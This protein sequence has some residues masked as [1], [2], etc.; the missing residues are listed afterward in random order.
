M[1]FRYHF[2]KFRREWHPQESP[3]TVP[4]RGASKHRT[5]PDTEFRSKT[6]SGAVW[7]LFC[8]VLLHIFVDVGRLEAPYWL[9]FLVYV[10]CVVVVFG[11][12]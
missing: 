3:K 4:G 9:Q 12:A 6:V 2:P 10:F 5:H 8:I 1:S 11:K 7:L